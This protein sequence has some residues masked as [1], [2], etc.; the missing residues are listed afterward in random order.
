LAPVQA[1][2]VLVD[3]LRHLAALHVLRAKRL[4]SA[5]RV[6]A[7][8]VGLV[9][10]WRHFPVVAGSAAAAV[11][12]AVVL[13]DPESARAH[14]RALAEIVAWTG[15]GPA[16]GAGGLLAAGALVVVARRRRDRG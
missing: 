1:L 10:R 12:V 8:R 9:G 11:F 14:R 13:A 16:L 2:R 15:V 6:V 7:R 5:G 4:V 3:L